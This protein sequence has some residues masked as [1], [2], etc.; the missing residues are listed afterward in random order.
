MIMISSVSVYSSYRVTNLMVERVEIQEAYNY[1][2]V[3][4]NIIHVIISFI[5]M[6]FVVKI[7]YQFFEKYSKQ[8]FLLTTFGLLLVL[9]I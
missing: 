8:I 6:V 4:R 1:F 9:V 3:L 2:Y 5:V 7:N